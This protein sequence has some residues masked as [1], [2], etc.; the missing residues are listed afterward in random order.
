MK[1][2][3][4]YGGIVSMAK[5]RTKT[6]KAYMSATLGKGKKTSQGGRNVS[7][8]T[9]NKNKRKSFKQYRGQGK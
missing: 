4:K 8:A 5:A 2:I 3:N 9:M 1:S 7:T 6:L